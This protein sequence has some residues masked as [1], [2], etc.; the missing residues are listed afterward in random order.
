MKY[1]KIFLYSIACSTLIISILINIVILSDKSE[2]IPQG[3]HIEYRSIDSRCINNTPN[4]ITCKSIMYEIDTYEVWDCDK[5]LDPPFD[6]GYIDTGG[7]PE[8][9]RPIIVC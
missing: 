4:I 9:F 6:T 5:Y 8:S 7:S 2:R 3:C 1:I